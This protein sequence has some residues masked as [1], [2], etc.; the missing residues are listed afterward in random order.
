MSVA[1]VAPKI[2]QNRLWAAEIFLLRAA[3]IRT[4]LGMFITT[5]IPADAAEFLCNGQ[6]EAATGMSF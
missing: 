3:R 4:R 1:A 6:G 2:G 5:V